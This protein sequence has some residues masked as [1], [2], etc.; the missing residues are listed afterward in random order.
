MRE[1]LFRQAMILGEEATER[2]A[3]K[4]VAVF[5]IG[6]VGSYLVEALSR[7][8]VGDLLLVDPDSIALSNVNRQLHALHSTVG[9]NKAETMKDRVLDINPECKVIADTRFVDGDNYTDFDL[10]G[11][12]YVAD[13]IDTVSSKL[14]L[15]EECTRLAT[16]IVSCMGTGN[17]LDPTRFEVADIYSTSVCPLARVMRTELKKR[18]IPA[19]K[20]VYSRETPIKPTLEVEDP[21][22]RA[23]PGSISYCPSTAGLIMASVIIEE[24]TR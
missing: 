6:G 15:I 14:L 20:V 12:D 22:R 23:T 4:R 8:G 9:R 7:S 24:I 11:Y 13:C 21:I 2:L 10:A 16:P 5:G 19:L 17:K 1:E 18:G 3:H